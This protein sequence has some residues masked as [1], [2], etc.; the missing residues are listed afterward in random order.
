MTALHQGLQP[1]ERRGSKPRCH[2][3]TH[4]SPTQVAA[5]LTDMVS[6][7]GSVSADDYW[8]PNGFV[9]TTEAQ[10]HLQTPLLPTDKQRKL[11]EW[12]LP[13]GRETAQTPNFD[14]ASTCTIEGKPGLL[15]V[16]AKAHTT[17][18]EGEAYGRR[19]AINASDGRK[20]SHVTIGKA[21][22]EARIGLGE[23]T[24]LSWGISRDTHYQMSNRFAWAWK[25]TQLGIPV[26]LGYLG[27]LSAN[28]MV[29]RG[30]PFPDH[31]AWEALVLDHSEPLFP[32]QVWNHRWLVNDVPFI[33][34]IASMHQALDG[35]ADV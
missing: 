3:L 13:A 8:M 12:W 21:I 27:F 7:W 10:L 2:W 28:E 30:N 5:H 4:G 31:T 16:E 20:E 6:P 22:E 24:L 14:I 32:S 29:D 17:E 1:K 26:I 23:A 18:L 15:L 19:L 34:V 33:P 25:L 35:E 9:D 11:G